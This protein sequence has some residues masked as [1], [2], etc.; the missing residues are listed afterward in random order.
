LIK[1]AATPLKAIE[2]VEAKQEPLKRL[3]VKDLTPAEKQIIQ[4]ESSFRTTA[5]NPKS[6]AFGLGQLIKSNRVKYAQKIGTHPDTTD[7]HDQILMFRHY[8]KDRYG[9][10]ER[11]WEFWK[12][13]NWY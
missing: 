11:A 8:T 1:S 4:K 3:T 12:Q 13:N 7:E 2:P 10:A 5:K 9:T 6:S